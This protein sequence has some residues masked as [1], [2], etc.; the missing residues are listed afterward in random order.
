MLDAP[1]QDWAAYRRLTRDSDTAWLR[2]LTLRDRFDLYAD[3][4]NIFWEARRRNPGDWERLDQ[5]HWNQKLATRLR[6]VDAFKK[7]DELRR[8]RAATD[9]TG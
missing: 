4:F 9:H 2:G 5:W 7:L 8:E 6:M 3:L 1:R